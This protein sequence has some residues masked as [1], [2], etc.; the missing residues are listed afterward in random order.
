MDTNA[1]KSFCSNME[2][3]KSIKHIIDVFAG[4]PISRGGVHSVDR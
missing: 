4:E 2:T 1:S 3:K